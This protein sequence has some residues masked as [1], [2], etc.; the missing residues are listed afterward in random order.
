MG[1]LLKSGTGWRL[2]WDADTPEF[3]ALVGA[4]DWAIELTEPEFDDFCRLAEQLSR[5]M[6]LMSAELMDEERIACELASELIWLEAE[7]FPEKYSLRLIVRS[8]R[9]AEGFWSA[10]AVPELLQT[11][12]L[13]KVF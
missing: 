12:P 4:D 9:Q 11:I 2:G 13:L 6:G 7:G 5:T 1:K 3:K 10:S 8:A